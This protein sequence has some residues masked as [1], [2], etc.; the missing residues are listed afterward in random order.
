MFCSSLLANGE[1]NGKQHYIIK[2]TQS[3][4]HKN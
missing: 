2:G 1:M 4:S 3:L